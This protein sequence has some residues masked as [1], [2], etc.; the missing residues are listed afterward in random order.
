MG[1]LRWVAVPARFKIGLRYSSVTGQMI[2]E[3]WEELFFVDDPEF[4]PLEEFAGQ[5]EGKFGKED[6]FAPRRVF[7]VGHETAPNEM[8]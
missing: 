4:D 3:R 7:A 1:H 2:R 5:G 6:P 8:L